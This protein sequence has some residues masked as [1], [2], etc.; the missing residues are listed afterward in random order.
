[1]EMNQVRGQKEL[2]DSHFNA[3]WGKALG[4]VRVMYR[5]YIM[6]LPLTD[7]RLDFVMLEP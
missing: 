7:P 3:A 6:Y 4:V 1:M 5:A 2:F